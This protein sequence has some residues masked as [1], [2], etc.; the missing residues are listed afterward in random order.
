MQKHFSYPLIVEDI[1]SGEQH[2][3]LIADN[4]NLK[5]IT[6]IL[7]IPETKSF[8]ADIYT[9]LSKKEHLLKVWGKVDA[10]LCLQSVISLEYFTK[11]YSPEFEVIFDTRATLNSQKGEDIDF[12]EDLPDIVIDGK[13]DLADIAL[14]QLALVLEDYPRQEGEIFEWKSEFSDEEDKKENPFKILEKLK[15]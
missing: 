13:I 14:E 15:K 1:S 4:E 9:K 11:S 6:E 10:E 7:Q 2:Y 12:D 3:H 8:Q 5:E